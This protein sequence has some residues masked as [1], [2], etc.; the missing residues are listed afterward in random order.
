MLSNDL[1]FLPAQRVKLPDPRVD[2]RGHAPI[3]YCYGHGGQRSAF[4]FTPICN[5]SHL[6]PVGLAFDAVLSSD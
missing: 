2:A 3:L 6:K 1:D 4:G 5:S